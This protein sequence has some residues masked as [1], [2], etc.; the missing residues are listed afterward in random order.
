MTLAR[1]IPGNLIQWLVAGA[2]ITALML[3]RTDWIGIQ[4]PPTSLTLPLADW[5]KSI[6]STIANNLQ[7]VFRAMALVLE[8]PIRWLRAFLLG[9]PWL[10]MVLLVAA[11]GW[12]AAGWRV[13]AFNTVGLLYIVAVGLWAKAAVTLS[14]V[15]IA[16]PLAVLLGLMTGILMQRYRVVR[17]AV[18]PILDIMQTMPT[19]AYLIPMLAFF[20][21]G[22]VVGVLASAI[23][24]VPPMARNVCVAIDRIPSAIVEA[25]R[26]SGTTDRQLLFHILLPT[27]LPGILLGVNQTIMAVLSMAVISSILGGSPD[28]GWEII[29][30]MKR[31]QFG[32]SIVAGLVLA[33]IAMMLD[34]TSAGFAQDRNRAPR[35][36][37]IWIAAM[38][39]AIVIFA[40]V[41]QLAVTIPTFKLNLAPSLDA[42]VT[43][44]T[45]HFY[46][47]TE[48]IKNG[49]LLYILLPLKIG[50]VGS[51]R[52]ATWGFDLT[53]LSISLFI[54]VFAVLSGAITIW[55][56]W[57]S[58]IAIALLCLVYFYGVI[59]LPWT[60]ISLIAVL[61]AFQA[62]GIFVALIMLCALLLPAVSG[63]WESSMIT[64]QISAAGVFLSFVL[65]VPI[66]IA[67]ALSDRLSAVLRPV[68]D[69]FQTMPIFV[70]L[71]P[72]IMVFL[73]GEFTALVA[74]VLYAIVP[75][76]RYTEHGLR[77]LPPQVIEAATSMGTTRSQRL[78]TVELPLA[79]PEILLGLNQTV[80]MA[81]SM[82]IVAALAGARGLGQDIMVALTWL[83]AGNG[84]VAG[85]CVAAL[86]IAV[87]RVI[88][89]WAAQKRIELGLEAS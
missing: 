82:V 19:F 3:L 8:Y 20:G 64:L 55:Q 45:T 35:V 14:L 70:F 43:W 29:L 17:R 88:Q 11:A 9:I 22:P 49:V 44:F 15:G 38:A 12:T 13:A 83:D 30:T 46:P 61:V 1:H 26:M 63:L 81:V 40:L 28:I 36:L 39:A 23:Y 73:V 75:A 34:R 27:A 53:P 41:P 4:S 71:I 58:G 85:L 31:A 32:D 6:V 77:N 10:G 51:V 48:A 54:L 5:V 66:G 68:W 57:R 69:T 67:A 24:A 78:F 52:A 79:L 56:G 37:G 42:A 60:V 33:L 74:I 47:L 2:I 16:V 84:I 50:V 89:A 7:P 65:G 80:M 18:E 59:G 25:G 21:L 86:A 87:D 62:G 72:A 76:A